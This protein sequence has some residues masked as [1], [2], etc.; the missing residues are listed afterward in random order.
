MIEEKVESPEQKPQAQ[1]ASA[2]E[3]FASGRIDSQAYEIL[4]MLYRLTNM[5]LFMP[6]LKYRLAATAMICN[7][8][9]ILGGQ[10]GSDN[11]AGSTELEP[12]SKKY[13]E[14]EDAK[15]PPTTDLPYSTASLQAQ[16]QLN[17]AEPNYGES[18][19]FLGYRGAAFDS[20]PKDSSRENYKDKTGPPTAPDYENSRVI[21][22]Y[23]VYGSE[24]TNGFTLNC[25]WE[26]IVSAQNGNF[27]DKLF[28]PSKG[29]VLSGPTEYDKTQLSR[30][31]MAWGNHLATGKYDV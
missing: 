10:A 25:G 11:P 13:R 31:V 7:K 19:L 18:E 17:V 29:R 22:N 1:S 20:S 2:Q 21:T 24:E 30:Q 12:T 14:S 6:Q 16:A 26:G 15:G 3:A 27:L 28:D 8:L 4:N 23:V 5:Q 9:G